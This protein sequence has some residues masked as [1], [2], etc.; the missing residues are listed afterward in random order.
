VIG[1]KTG[2]VVASVA[3]LAWSTA[4]RAEK[5]TTEFASGA[6]RPKSIAL[7]P[8]EATVTR[9]RIVETEGLVDESVVYGE[10]FNAQVQA[11]MTAKGYEV[12]VLEPDRIN[13]DPQLQEYFVDANR[14]FDDMM[15]KYKPKKLPSRIY[16]AGDSVRLL[17]DH[18]GVDAIAFSTL[19][20]TITPAGKAIV[21]GLLG[22]STSGTGSNL[23]IVNGDTGDLEAVFWGIA[24]V[25]PG[26]KTDQEM[27]GYV[28]AVAER[29]MNRL[30]SADPSA[31]IE[32]A[33]GEEEVLDE[34]ESLLEE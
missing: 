33:L 27:Q 17:A 3:A 14:G 6:T 4:G 16:N 24:I 23:A 9:A 7:L 8:V 11:L 5:T 34:V 22:G 15:S 21:S 29:T 12:Q 25:T 20:M 31:R 1:A 13:G 28:V 18:L 32:V 2:I 10:L 19:S 30:P 26:E